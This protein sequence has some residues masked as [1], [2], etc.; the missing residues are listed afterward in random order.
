[1]TGHG[2]KLVPTS[3]FTEKLLQDLQRQ[4]EE[5]DNGDVIEVEDMNELERWL[6]K[7]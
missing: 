7:K 1:M 4:D 2:L 6:K 5:M 3:L